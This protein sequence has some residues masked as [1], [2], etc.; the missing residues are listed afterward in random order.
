[1]NIPGPIAQSVGSPIAD[2]GVMS[3][4][5]KVCA[6]STGQLLSQAC[7]DKSVIRLTDHLDMI[8][9]VDSDIKIQIKQTKTM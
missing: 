3:S 4:I 8:I 2:P 1:M 7:P 5:S 9:A 6:Q